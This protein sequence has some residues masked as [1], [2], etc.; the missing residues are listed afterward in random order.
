MPHAKLVWSLGSG[1]TEGFPST[2]QLDTMWAIRLFLG[3]MREITVISTEK[4]PKWTN[5][6]IQPPT[7]PPSRQKNKAKNQKNQGPNP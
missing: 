3:K 6:K 1:F 5:Q 7:S 4:T 2:M